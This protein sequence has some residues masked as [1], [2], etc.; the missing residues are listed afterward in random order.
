MSGLAISLGDPWGI[1]PEITARA[2]ARLLPEPADICLV[3]PEFAFREMCR[4]EPAL[5]RYRDSLVAVPWSGAVARPGSPPDDGGRL[6]LETLARTVSLVAGRRVS[7]IVTAPVNKALIHG[8]DPSFIGHTEYYGT[9]FG[10]PE[11]TMTF[12]GP[13]LLTALVTTHLALCDLPA[14]IT[15]ERVRLHLGRLADWT[16]ATRGPEARI[17]VCGLNP[18][19]GEAGAFGR[20]EIDSIG[21]AVAD[22]GREGWPVEGPFPAD[23]LYRQGLPGGR[24]AAILA[25]YHDQALVLFKTT[26]RGEG[27]NMTLGLPVVRTSPDHGTAYDIAGQGAADATSML[28]AIR[29]AQTA[30]AARAGA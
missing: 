26:D 27:V 5:E 23:S 20:E 15:R 19:A 17:G 3:G 30:A 16:R 9:A 10:V 8:V 24:Y 13:E 1:G 28:A 18:H 12:V 21:P 4:L 14:A 7:A 11:P 29:L 22:L 6:V 2:L 25:K